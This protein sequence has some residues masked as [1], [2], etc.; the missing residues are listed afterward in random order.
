VDE[1]ISKRARSPESLQLII[2]VLKFY[3]KA[4][5]VLLT[6]AYVAMATSAVKIYIASYQLFLRAAA[7][8]ITCRHYRKKRHIKS[9]NAFLNEIP[10]A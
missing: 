9:K 6:F 5:N 1:A 2:S 10:R 8:V 3:R 4:I 7:E